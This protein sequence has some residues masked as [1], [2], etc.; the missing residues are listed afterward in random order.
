MGMSDRLYNLAKSYL[1]SARTRWDEVDP[2]AQK[3]L[4]NAVSSPALA[5]WERAQNKIKSAQAANQ[6]LSE[7]R[8]SQSTPPPTGQA[9]DRN[10]LPPP[11]QQPS[12]TALTAAYRVLDLPEGSDLATVQKAYQDFKLKADP[13]RFPDGS[14]DNVLAKNIIRRVNAAY[15]VLANSL[16]TS[17]DDRFDR[18]EL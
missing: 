1:D 8:Q 12:T 18:L 15:I 13:S 17:S 7:L 3:E 6:A 5:A 2:A 11:I 14:K 9:F 16:S 4:D 10:Q